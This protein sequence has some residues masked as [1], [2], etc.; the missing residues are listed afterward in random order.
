M[1]RRKVGVDSLGLE[2]NIVAVSVAMFRLAFGE[3]LWKRFLPKYLQPF[4][5]A[6][7]VAFSL[8]PV[9]VVLSHDFATLVLA[10]V[11]GASARS[12]SRL[13]RP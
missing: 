10:F 11:V 13:G 9:A 12:A 7:F 5:I 1:R 8:F 4:V 6:T 3:N 2:R